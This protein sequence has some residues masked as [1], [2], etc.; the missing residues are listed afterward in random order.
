VRVAIRSRSSS[1]ERLYGVV[2]TALGAFFLF[3][4]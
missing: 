3:H 1:L 4:I 2:L